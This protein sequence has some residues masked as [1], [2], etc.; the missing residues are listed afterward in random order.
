MRP[1]LAHLLRV[2][3]CTATFNPAHAP[4]TACRPS[5]SDRSCACDWAKDATN[6]ATFSGLSH[7]AD[8]TSAEIA[9][10]GLTEQVVK[11]ADSSTQACE[12]VCCKAL[13]I[14][15]APAAAQAPA[16]TGPCDIWQ[17]GGG[18]GAAG[19]WLGI[20][21]SKRRPPLPIVQGQTAIWAGGT[22]RL[23]NSNWGWSFL[24]VACLGAG[25]Y[26]GGGVVA[27]GRVAGQ[28]R[29]VQAHPHYSAW[30]QIYGMVIDGFRLTRSRVHGGGRATEAVSEATTRQT[31]GKVT[32]SP[33]S[34]DKTKRKGKHKGEHGA[35]TSTASGR[36]ERKPGDTMSR[37]NLDE[38][39]VASAS[40]SPS[41]SQET[42]Q[43][44]T[45]EAGGGGR[46]VHVP[47]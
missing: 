27:G 19:C 35:K 2:V 9:A 37:G 3:I 33:K 45:T 20:D 28:V 38:S 1:A 39:L 11:A 10:T 42:S 15:D 8:W 41:T 7:P 23:A 4:I 34:S 21:N 47:S 36:M 18:T 16:Q 22:G 24:A 5:G 25:I 6:T 12:L 40:Q 26:V 43:S 44:Q 14:T 31:D 30:L 29:G 17:H 13:L 32:D 46:W